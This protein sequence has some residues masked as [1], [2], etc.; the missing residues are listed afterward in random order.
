MAVATSSKRGTFT[1]KTRHLKELF[2]LFEG[3]I[4]CSDDVDP[5]T[6]ES[7][8]PEGRGKP[9]PDIY[10][11]AAKKMLNLPLTITEDP[12]QISAE[13]LSLRKKGLVFEDAIPGV[14][15][16]L[17]AGMNVVWIPDPNLLAIQTKQGI[18][19]PVVDETI[20]SMEEFVPEKWG[21][22]PY[23]DVE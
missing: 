2:D 7:V 16:G 5:E 12:E 10:L 17:R 15:A 8:I 9:A 14:E 13:E 6:G 21:L 19:F 1:F 18:A 22:P 23:D 20:M 3:R 4:V 11:T